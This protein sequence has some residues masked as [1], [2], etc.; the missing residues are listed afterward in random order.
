MKLGHLEIRIGPC[1]DTLFGAG[2]KSAC[3]WTSR[4]SVMSRVVRF[5]P[6]H[7]FRQQLR[8]ARRSEAC[9]KVAGGFRAA[10]LCPRNPDVRKEVI[11]QHRRLAW[12]WI[13]TRPTGNIDLMLDLATL[14]WPRNSLSTC[15]STHKIAA[16]SLSHDLGYL[17][18]TKRLVSTVVIQVGLFWLL[19]ATALLYV[20]HEVCPGTP[21]GARFGMLRTS[22]GK[23]ATFS[24]QVEVGN[25]FTT[26][27]VAASLRRQGC[28]ILSLRCLAAARVETS[29]TIYMLHVL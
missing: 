22:C 13:Q 23:S 18:F 8:I 2:L 9:R 11:E 24:Q 21:F 5:G 3:R 15:L 17:A 26:Q 20:F 25:T 10:C 6:Q 14:E 7:N 4:V 29:W 1:S 12:R 27:R 19:L 16:S 28:G